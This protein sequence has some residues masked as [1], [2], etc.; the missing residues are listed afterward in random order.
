M[1]NDTNEQ[2]VSWR[3]HDWLKAAGHPFSLP[4]LYNEIRAGRLDA[5]KVAG[6]KNHGHPN[7][8]ARVLREDAE[9]HR[10]GGQAQEGGRGMS[11]FKVTL[12]EL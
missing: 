3:P 7:F 9:G 2:Q 10:P 1:A 11:A 4:V 5:R 12:E 8:G 6:G